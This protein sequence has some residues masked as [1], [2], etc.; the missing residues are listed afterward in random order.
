MSPR[1]VPKT[2]DP[3]IA[4]VT[5]KQ[6]DGE[7]DHAV[8]AFLR[9][10]EIKA[11]ERDALTDSIR[12]YR[13]GGAF[14]YFRDLY[15]VYL[16]ERHRY[17]AS[18]SIALRGLESG[19]RSG[20]TLDRD[21]PIANVHKRLRAV[22]VSEPR[23]LSSA[24][25]ADVLRPS[26]PDWIGEVFGAASRQAGTL[27]DVLE[28]RPLLPG[29]VDTSSGVPVIS[30]IPRLSGGSA[31]AIQASQNSLVQETDPTTTTVNYPVGML[32]GQV[33]MS[34]QL[35]ELSSP[36]MDEVISRDLGADFGTK[37]DVQIVNGSGASGQLR[38]LLNT[39]GI[40]TVAGSVSTAAAFQQSVWQAYSSLPERPGSGLTTRTSSSR[41]FILAGW[42]GYAATRPE[43]RR[44]RS[45]LERLPSAL[46][47]PRT[48]V[49]G[50]TK[51]ARSSLSARTSSLP[52]ASPRSAS[53][54]R[55]AAER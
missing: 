8:E 53:S 52:A 47:S 51:T 41:F 7:P 49:L 46:V 40:L 39:S 35:F 42:P 25:A 50:Q 13:N 10:A 5:A 12:P 45:C 4:T 54:S 31:V 48:S 34:R 1:Y 14:S 43:S 6:V 55:Q 36:A 27:A 3:A 19:E 17:E 38:G 44:R 18:R 26:A 9:D 30:A 29:M 23:D 11:A 15:R 28:R 22:W 33:D 37:L 16:D 2:D 20:F 32:A 24:N 21:D